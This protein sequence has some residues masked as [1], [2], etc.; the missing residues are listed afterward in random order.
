MYKTRQAIKWRKK[1]SNESHWNVQAVG[2]QNKLLAL[3]LKKN[4]AKL[5]IETIES[6]RKV[7]WLSGDKLTNTDKWG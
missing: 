6:R 7:L 5:Y 2:Q 4:G 1:Q 3:K